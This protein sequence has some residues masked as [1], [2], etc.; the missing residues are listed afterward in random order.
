M[1]RSTGLTP[2]LAVLLRYFGGA[3]GGWPAGVDT[4][5]RCPCEAPNGR[6]LKVVHRA[7]WRASAECCV[8]SH[9]SA[10]MPLRSYTTLPSRN[11]SSQTS[12]FVPIIFV[13]YIS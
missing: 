10:E 2:S 9:M 4:G 8:A 12:F 5:K 3:G 11:V 6:S 1:S 7:D 13:L